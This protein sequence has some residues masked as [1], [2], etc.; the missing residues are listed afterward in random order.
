MKPSGRAPEK[1]AETPSPLARQHVAVERQNALR[2]SA[3]SC[4]RIGDLTASRQYESR[5]SVRAGSIFLNVDQLRDHLHSRHVAM[6]GT[7]NAS[8]HVCIRGSVVFVHRVRGA[9][10]RLRLCTVSIVTSHS[11]AYSPVYRTSNLRHVPNRVLSMRKN[12]A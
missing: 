2:T 4:C 11:A 9:S 6:S 3:I 8:T 7:H 5:M 12:E 1:R 10:A